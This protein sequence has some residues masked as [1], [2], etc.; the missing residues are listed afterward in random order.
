MV[1]KD[2]RKQGKSSA[3]LLVRP[4]EGSRPKVGSASTPAKTPEVRG[5]KAPGH[6]EAVKGKGSAVR[7]KEKE[8]HVAMGV[9][10]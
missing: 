7:T 4:T 1:R 3:K 2:Q 10:G 6:E 8:D 5:P 9:G